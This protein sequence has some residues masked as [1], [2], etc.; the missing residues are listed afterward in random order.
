M[1]GYRLPAASY[2]TS[3]AVS[4]LQ[5]GSPA[6]RRV[7]TT[8][9]LYVRAQPQQNASAPLERQH[10]VPVRE[11]SALGGGRGARVLM[12][13]DVRSVHGGVSSGSC[14]VTRCGGC[15]IP[16]ECCIDNITDPM[17]GTT[18]VGNAERQGYAALCALHL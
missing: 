5:K 14:P 12:F 10:R 11:D 2:L 4:I 8:D 18:V 9:A 16:Q 7:G 1:R 6:R 13:M 3:R 15:G 17:T